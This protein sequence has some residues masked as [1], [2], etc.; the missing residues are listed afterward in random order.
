MTGDDTACSTAG[1]GA[2]PPKGTQA[3][4]ASQQRWDR[5]RWVLLAC[6]LVVAGATV[7]TGERASSWDQVRT[8]VAAGDVDTVRVVGEL[9]VRGTGF[10]EVEI[11]WRRG[12]VGYRAAVLQIR[13]RG[14]RDAQA[15]REGVTGVVHGSP[16]SRLTDLQPGLEVTQGRDRSL[17]GRPLLGWVM[18]NWL[19]L[20]AALPFFAGLAVLIAGPQ[21]WR[22]TR[23]AWFWLQVPPI[24]GIVFLL[25]SGPTRCVP[26]PRFPPRRLTGGWA[27]LLSLPLA[28]ILTPYRW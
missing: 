8:L 3:R 11:H 20:F 7:L 24:G 25:A 9:P 12:P 19:G 28:G 1:E 26:R 16:T 23:W 6:W 27:F 2:R 22:A 15:A 21:P 5:I 10:S 17:G 14:P 13:G 18:P 4:S